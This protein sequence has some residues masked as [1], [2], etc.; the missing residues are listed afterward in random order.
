MV[1]NALIR[2]YDSCSTL[3][4]ENGTLNWLF[5]SGFGGFSKWDSVYFLK[6][7]KE[8][9]V[10]EQYMAFF[11]F[12]P[13]LIRAV[14]QILPSIDEDTRHLVSG[15]IIS[16]SSFIAAAFALYKL[17]QEI[18]RD[19]HLAFI[20]ST[21]FCFNPAT[22]FMSTLYTESTFAFLEF[23]G[24]YFMEKGGVCDLFF[25]S[26]FLGLGSATRSNGTLA[27]G[28][29]SHATLRAFVKELVTSTGLPKKEKNVAKIVYRSGAVLLKLI[30]LNFIILAPFLA[31]QA[32]GYLTYCSEGVQSKAFLSSWCSKSLPLSYTYIQQHYWN[33]GFLKYFELKQLPNFVLATPMVVLCS[34]AI[35]SYF[36]RR[37]NFEALKSLG[38]KLSSSKITENLLKNKQATRAAYH[39][40]RL[41]VYL[42]HLTFI[43]VFGVTSMHVQ[44]KGTSKYVLFSATLAFGSN[45]QSN[46]I[47]MNSIPIT[48]L[49]VEY[50]FG[51]VAM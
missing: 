28:F 20:T 47:S 39:N 41:F 26:V 6:I 45:E 34:S 14:S 5:E 51:G 49:H 50:P 25:A 27:C 36:G 22:V 42:V 40:P 32:Y 21:L 9:Y 3:R 43:M 23:S 33:V 46:H 13:T 29:V 1:F 31:Y 12:Y 18:L 17:S 35:Y 19:K 38:L 7:S 8:G 10:Y 15:W 2:D 16:N 37:E 48:Y 11:P 4:V 30:V 24:L 44:V